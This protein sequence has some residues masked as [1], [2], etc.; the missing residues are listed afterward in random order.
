MGQNALGKE[1]TAA[2]INTPQLG[3]ITFFRDT[4]DNKFKV[5]LDDGTVISI[6]CALTLQEVTDHGNTTDRPIGT[7]EVQDVNDLV[8]KMLI[9]SGPN[10]ASNK[11][12]F[13]AGSITGAAIKFQFG[14]VNDNSIPADD[15]HWVLTNRGNVPV[16]N[17][18]NN[19]IFADDAA[20]IAGG[21]LSGDIYETDGGAAAPLNIAGLLVVVQ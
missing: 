5:K 12:M 14:I 3:D 17:L 9:D 8:S 21:L 13:E 7:N 18:L 15:G 10:A 16:M 4:A 11:A 2:N 20:A 6:C 1:T 19:P